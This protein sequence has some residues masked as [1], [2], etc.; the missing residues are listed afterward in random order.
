MNLFDDYDR[1]LKGHMKSSKLHCLFVQIQRGV[2]LENSFSWCQWASA[3]GDHRG[4]LV[5][6]AM[7]LLKFGSEIYYA[8]LVLGLVIHEINGSS[9]KELLLVHR[10]PRPLRKASSPAQKG[11]I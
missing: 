8:N 7:E 5:L 2:V 4:V 6:T 11:R 10:W 1:C 9:T 3:W